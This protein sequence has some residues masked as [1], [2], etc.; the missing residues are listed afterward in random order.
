MNAPSEA[1]KRIQTLSNL[2]GFDVPKL[3]MHFQKPNEISYVLDGT[4]DDIARLKRATSNASELI[5]GGIEAITDLLLKIEL[6]DD[7]LE[8]GL[9]SETRV[10]AIALIFELSKIMRVV[11]EMQ[12]LLDQATPKNEQTQKNP[13]L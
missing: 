2:F 6:N 4:A 11:N 13:E 3:Q 9:D 8:W 7:V 1:P 10:D 5:S 12:L